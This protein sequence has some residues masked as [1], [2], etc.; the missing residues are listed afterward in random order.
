M[1]L[2]I[3]RKGQT[4]ILLAAGLVLAYVLLAMLRPVNHDESQY[5]AAT[6]LAKSAL[7]WRD[8]AYFQTP[9]Q[10]MLLAPFAVT[11]GTLAWPGLRVINAL[12]GALAVIGVARAAREA[13]ASERM[14]IAAAALF[15]TTDILLFSAGV[16]RNDALPAAALAW[17]LIPIVRA[18]QGK[19]HAVQAALAGLLLAIAAGSKISY[20]L[21]AI[22]YFGWALADRRHRPLMVALGALPVVA[23]V[24]WLWLQAPEAAR[25]E[26]LGFPSIAPDQMYRDAGRAY[27]LSLGFKAIDTLKFLALGAALPALAAVAARWRRREAGP[28][29][30][31]EV[32]VIAGL[33]AALLPEPTWRQYLLPALPPV[34]V[35]LALAWDRSAPG[36]WERIAFVAFACAG[37]AP[38]VE[39][40]VFAAQNGVPMAV[41]IA[42]GRAI[43][44]AMDKQGVTG[45]VAT[46]APQYVAATDKPLDRRFAAGPFYFRSHGLLDPADEQK[47]ALLSSARMTPDL[48]PQA[49]LVGG[50]SDTEGGDAALEAKLAAAAGPRAVSI[51]RLRNGKFTLYVL[52]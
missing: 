15:A 34:F 30:V 4:G 14:T 33:V 3:I 48:L 17:A 1:L 46:L 8:F 11:L 36:R 29:R 43:A 7:P 27:K 47:F 35:C 16:V 19:G 10:P 18:T 5:V 22:A 13:G 41:A 25:F 51:L 42:D 44:K 45:G 9:L 24:G 31:L 38:S 21:P 26:V 39:A 6:V 28:A 52:R 49:V 23:F 32:L 2:R 50:D 12:L 37:L 20:A 40:A